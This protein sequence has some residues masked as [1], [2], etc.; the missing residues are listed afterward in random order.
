MSTPSEGHSKKP[1]ATN[2]GRESKRKK[3]L[4][5]QILYGA[6]PIIDLGHRIYQ[7]PSQSNGAYY[8]V[9]LQRDTC[10]CPDWR[11]RKRACKH[12]YAARQ[13]RADIECDPGDVPEPNPHKNPPYYDRLRAVQRHCIR[14]MLRCIGKKTTSAMDATG[15]N[16]EA[17]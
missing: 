17:A 11:K 16:N 3:N 2:T 9:N 13:Y 15:R 6:T 1:P 12:I 4:A 5:L 8:T 7:V 14:H 10:S